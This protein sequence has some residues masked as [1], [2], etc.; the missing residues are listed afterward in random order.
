MIAATGER[1]PSEIGRLLCDREWE[2]QNPGS[3]PRRGGVSV[4]RRENYTG[5]CY[6]GRLRQRGLVQLDVRNACYSLT[7]A[8]KAML[9][10][11]ATEAA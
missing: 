2:R 11:H 4:G 7:D 8:G 5:G 3:P 10:E 9:H 6:L 1:H